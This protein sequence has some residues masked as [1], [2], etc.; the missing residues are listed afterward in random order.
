MVTG[1]ESMTSDASAA[2]LSPVSPAPVCSRPRWWLAAPLGVI[3]FLAV[4]LTARDPG[5]TWDEAIYCGRA[6]HY[7]NWFQDLSAASFGP[8]AVAWTW[9]A[10]DHPPLG[11]LWIAGAFVLFGPFCD[12]LTAARL[13]AAVL[14]GLTLAVIFLWA[15]ARRGDRA[16]LLASALFLLMPRVF[17]HAH[18]ANLEMLTLL[19][20]LLTVAAFE[21]G[22][23]NRVWSVLCGIFFGL[24]L[25]AKV[26]GVFLPLVLVPWGLLFHGRRALR[27]IGCMALL[28]PALFFLGWPVLWHFPVTGLE[29]YL[30]DKT[31]R[32]VIPVQYLGRLYRD[33]FAPWHYPCVML[34]A[35]T[36]LPIL[37]G[38]AAGTAAAVR[39]LCA[40]WRAAA[41]DALLLGAGAFPLLLLAQPGV[42]KYDGIRLLLPALPFLAMFA[43]DGLL[44]TWD[45]CRAAA[46]PG[47]PPRRWPAA[48]AALLGLWLLLPVCL[49][50]PHQMAYYGEL[51][52]GPA[53]ARRLG[54]ETTYW[55]DTLDRRALAFLN[56]HVPADGA[57][58]LVAAGEFV[59]ESYVLLGEVRRDIRL[60]PFQ[61]GGWDYLVVIPRQGLWDEQVHAWVATREPVWSHR[62]PAPGWVPVCLIYRR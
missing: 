27:N 11:C 36:P 29:A 32:M 19:L 9:S 61:A 7:L 10:H 8:E 35:T 41:G 1:S 47:Q 60:V 3:A 40:R 39:R 33:R 51:T 43:A 17:A 57:V 28:G 38:A 26:N 24:A 34:L 23:E 30:L 6:A 49:F 13:G 52:G 22:I 46:G 5:L 44:D 45:R 58:A 16:G 4:A 59:W 56:Q 12:M 55:G 14:F 25:L 20:W 54:L 21:R 53:G 37:V 15:A 48:A 31:R 2:A 50:H 18:F 42:P 62:L